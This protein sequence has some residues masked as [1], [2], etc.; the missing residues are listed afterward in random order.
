MSKITVLGAGSWGTALATIFANANHEVRLWSRNMNMEPCVKGSE[1][2]I[3]AVPSHGV[4]ET[5]EKLSPYYV[6]NQIIVNVCK[7]L[8]EETLMLLAN[9]VKNEIKNAEIAVMSGPSHAEEVLQNLPTTNVIASTNPD[10]LKKLQKILTTPHFRLYASSD[11]IGVQIAGSLK[12][13]IAILAGVSDGLGFGDNTR[14]ALMTRGIAEISRL[15]VA[16]GAQEKTFAGLAGIGDVIAT[17]TSVHSRNRRAGIMLAQGKSL[18]QALD[19]IKMVVE[20][21]RTTTAAYALKNK[22][23]IDA[24]LISESHAI[25]FKGKNPQKAVEDLMTRKLK[26][27]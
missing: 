24:P 17:C 5:A 23:Q 20:G 11:I 21:V 14:A 2:I 6:E 7:G 15:G 9:V 10:I 8:E 27:E 13:I 19:E 26:W 16:I 25:L 1:I 12:N 18:K 22:H 3:N 4:R